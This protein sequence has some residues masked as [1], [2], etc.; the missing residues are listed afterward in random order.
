VRLE[1]LGQ[2]KNPMTSSAIEPATF[3]LV[4]IANAFMK[5]VLK[6]FQCHEE[7]GETWYTHIMFPLSYHISTG[8]ISRLKFI[9]SFIH[10]ARESFLTW[11]ESYCNNLPT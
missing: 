7:I 9:H 5:F 4:P 1:G 3:R 6:H 2:L 10:P 8:L 11:P